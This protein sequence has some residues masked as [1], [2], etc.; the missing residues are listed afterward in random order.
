[1]F[2][3]K[4]I[5]CFIFFAFIFAGCSSINIF[6]P[7]SN[8]TTDTN[9]ITDKLTKPEAVE[10][11]DGLYSDKINITWTCAGADKYY[12][13]RSSTEKNFKIF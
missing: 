8:N 11:S 2:N 1:M 7:I 3:Y 6:D 4:S 9:S 5:L 12:I 13:Y 10:A